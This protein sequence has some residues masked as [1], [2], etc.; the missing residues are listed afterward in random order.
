[1]SPK[2]L[3]PKIKKNKIKTQ[4]QKQTK[5]EIKSPKIKRPSSAISSKPKIP[6]KSKLES[7][8]P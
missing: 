5:E 4:V 1:M 7:H 6:I 2:I 3:P 8:L